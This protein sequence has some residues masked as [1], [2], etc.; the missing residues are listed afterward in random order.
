MTADEERIE[1]E[2]TRWRAA[3]H[4]FAARAERLAE[5]VVELSK[6]NIELR[7]DLAACRAALKLAKEE[8]ADGAG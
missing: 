5:R 7:A 1:R 4:A 8:D 6:A 3:C 2:V